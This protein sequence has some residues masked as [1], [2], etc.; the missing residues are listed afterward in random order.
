VSCK[1]SFAVPTFQ[2]AAPRFLSFLTFIAYRP[3]G[4]SPFFRGGRFWVLAAR[5]FRTS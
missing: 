1:N 3:V 4:V 2:P 5:F